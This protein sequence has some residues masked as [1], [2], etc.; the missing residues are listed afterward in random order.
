MNLVNVDSDH[1]D[2]ADSAGPA[3][4]LLAALL[5]CSSAGPSTPAPALALDPS[6]QVPYT[7]QRLPN[8][9]AARFFCSGARSTL[10]QQRL[11]EMLS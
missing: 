4:A 2:A 7:S 10:R 8:G 11:S 1:A 3:G 5:A 6:Y 9:D